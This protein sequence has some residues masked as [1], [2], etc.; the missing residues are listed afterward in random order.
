MTPTIVTCRVTVAGHSIAA[1]TQARIGIW[2]ESQV[3]EVGVALQASRVSTPE[4]VT[5]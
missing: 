1:T 3:G 2:L 5:L 4:S